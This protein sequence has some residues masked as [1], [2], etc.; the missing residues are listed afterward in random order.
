MNE[1]KTERKRHVVRVTSPDTACG[2]VGHMTVDQLKEV[3]VGDDF[4]ANCPVC[5]MIH[6]TAAEIAEVEARKTT[7][8]PEYRDTASQARAEAE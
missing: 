3:A 5:G 2:Y 4:E 1:D 8:T 6:L 7:E